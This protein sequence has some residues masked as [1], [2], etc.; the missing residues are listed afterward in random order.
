MDLPK[1][2]AFF[3]LF[4][5]LSFASVNAVIFTPALP[6]ISIFFSVSSDQAQHLVVY[7]LIGYTLGQLLYSPL[8]NRFG[9]K[10]ALYAGISLQILS[11]LICI[12]AG[13]LY[14]FYLLLV[15]AFL[16][17]LGSGVGLKMTYT[18]VSECYSAKIAGEKI[19]YLILSFAIMPAASVALGGFLNQYFN[20]V[21]CFY[22]AALY[23]L[24]LLIFSFKLPETL[25]TLNLNALKLRPLLTGYLTQFKN[26]QLVAAGLL[27]GCC[28]SFVYLFSALSPFI[29]INIFHINSAQYGLAN[30]L[31]L[32]GLILGS[33]T[34]A[35]ISQYF[36]IKTIVLF[37]I[38][39][40]AVG[41]MLMLIMVL[42]KLSVIF[43][44]FLPM[45]IIYFGICFVIANAS[46]L[47]LNKATDK[48]HGSAVLNFLNMGLATVF[49]LGLSYFPIKTIILPSAYFF[50][51]VLML[52][53]YF[54]VRK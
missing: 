12:L 30:S 16:L 41:V 13:H 15:G 45:I 29:A 33:L 3:T 6:N 50:I 37:G 32:I 23:G 31:P 46:T 17:A 20:W 51:L 11:C 35:R 8:A 40:G 52:I 42:L 19:S 4:L 47:A 36:S 9:R 48:S 5:L 53:L 39:C 22:A 24:I 25:V 2:P 26:P 21:S 10:P 43:T 34:S 44:V 54:P 28:S 38:F 14:N 27:V 1:Q 7:F 49:V 18:L